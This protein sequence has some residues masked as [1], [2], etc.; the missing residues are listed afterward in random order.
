MKQ[1]PKFT[2]SISCLAFSPDGSK[3]AIG[4]SNEHDNSLPAVGEEARIVA[5]M[6]KDTVMEDCKVCQPGLWTRRSANEIAK[7][8]GLE[9]R[10]RSRII[11]ECMRSAIVVESD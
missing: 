1:Y 8:K 6:I 7:G 4:A 2:I 10:C 3:L 11:L 5:L 9:G